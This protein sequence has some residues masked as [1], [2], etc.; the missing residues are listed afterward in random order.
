MTEHQ[1]SVRIKPVYC[2]AHLHPVDLETRDPAGWNVLELPSWRGAVVAH[3]P[4]EYVRMQAL[5]R[6]LPS[7]LNGF[8]I[9]PQNPRRDT[10]EFLSGLAAQG[11]IDYIG[12]AGFDFFGDTPLRM[13]T[14]QNL[15]LQR[16]VFEFQLALAERYNLSLVVHTRKAMDIVLGYGRKLARLP[17]VIF[18]SWP[19]RAQDAE[20]ILRHG[21][22]A[23]FSFGTTILRG[24]KHALESC[25]LIAENRILSETDAPW[26]PPRGVEWTGA[27]QIVDVVDTIAKVR[28]KPIGY[29]QAFLSEN[30]FS[31]FGTRE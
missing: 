19:G 15:Y 5:R 11:E 10:M 14:S 7:T 1:A 12:E 25:S 2:D 13:R 30:F 16:E 23:Y 27:G 17:A 3:D 20:A 24:A 18:H 4:D 31:A 21:I 29:T 22:N 28:G 9:H 8:G 26:Q 6:Q